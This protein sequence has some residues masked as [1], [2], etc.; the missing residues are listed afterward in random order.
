MAFSGTLLTIGSTAISGLRS[1]SVQYNKL[2]KDA[3]RNM[4]GN[5]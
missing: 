4:A 1:Y 3:E 5:I 2:W